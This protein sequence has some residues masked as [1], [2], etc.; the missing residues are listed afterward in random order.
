MKKKKKQQ[1]S[2]NGTRLSLKA[3][4]TAKD[5]T[6][7]MKRPHTEWEEIFANEM[8]DNGLISKI[9]K[10]LMWLNITKTTQLKNGQKI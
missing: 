8:T 5:T 10:Q 4:C 2:K 7:Q 9:Y 3:F 1:K 6:N